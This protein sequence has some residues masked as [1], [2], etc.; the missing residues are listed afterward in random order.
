MSP[1]RL[2]M[3][4]ACVCL[5]LIGCTETPTVDT[6]AE[7]DAIRDIDAQWTVADQAGD[8]EKIV[9]LA[10]P[11]IVFLYPNE[12]GGVGRK[13]FRK[14]LEAWLADTIVSRTYSATMQAVEVA[15]SGDI[16]YTRGTARWKQTA[17]DGLVDYSVNWVTVYRKIEGQWKAVVDI[18]TPAGQ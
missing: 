8:V 4:L 7:A 2:R 9:S 1:S 11:D 16:A 18:S 10:G 13:A 14:E 15:A 17:Q 3:L 12:P 6:H 5:V